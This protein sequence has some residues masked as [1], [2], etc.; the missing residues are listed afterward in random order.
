MVKFMQNLFIIHSYNGSTKT[1]LG[2]KSGITELLEALEIIG[3]HT[4]KSCK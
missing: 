1:H 3:K 4:I 2:S